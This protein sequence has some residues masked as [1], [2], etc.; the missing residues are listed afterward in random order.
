MSDNWN[1]LRSQLEYF[2]KPFPHAAIIFANEHREELTPFLVGVLASVAADPSITED[3]N[4]MLHLYAMHLL[5][6]WREPS[7]YIPMVA[8]GCHTEEVIDSMMGDTVTEGYPRCLASVCNGDITELK[9]LF[10]NTNISYWARLAAMTALKI[11]VLEGDGSREELIAYLTIYGD[12]EASRLSEKGRDGLEVLDS[13]VSTAAKISAIEMKDRIENWFDNNLL[14]TQYSTKKWSLEKIVV[15]FQIETSS[16]FQE[17][18][19]YI[20]DAAKAMQWWASFR[21]TSIKNNTPFHAKQKIGRND[22]CPCGSGAKYK[23]CHG[24]D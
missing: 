22:P 18:S 13:I 16:I 19:G 4:Y 20:R 15:P 24:A 23:R 7:A 9:N 21:D 2:S 5:S 3:G 10:E 14:D 8:L 11:R 6:A 17:H 12:L 1:T